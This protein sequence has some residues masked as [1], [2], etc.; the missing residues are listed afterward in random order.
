MAYFQKQYSE[1]REINQNQKQV[2][3]QLQRDLSGKDRNIDNLIAQVN[4]LIEDTMSV[5]TF[6]DGEYL[7]SV[8]QVVQDLHSFGVGVKHIGQKIQTVLKHLVGIEGVKVPSESSSRRMILESNLLATLQVGEIMLSHG[9]N[10]LHFDGTTDAQKHFLGF[11]ISTPGQNLSLFISKTIRG[12]TQ[13]QVDTLKQVFNDLSD[14][15][16]SNSTEKNKGQIH[17]NFMI[18]VKNLISDQHIVNKIFLDDLTKLR[19]FLLEECDTNWCNLSEN[20][21]LSNTPIF[22]SSPCVG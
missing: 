20:E 3:L 5:E 6:S 17:A 8:R 7:P 19:T 21:G 13:T 16:S 22:L 14:V 10:T 2:I 12:D 11:Q 15:M 4:E 18:S 1:Y 9:L